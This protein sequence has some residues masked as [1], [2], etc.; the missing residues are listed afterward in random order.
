M[1]IDNIISYINLAG[2]LIAPVGFFFWVKFKI[3]QTDEQLTELKQQHKEDCNDI[4]KTFKEELLSVKHGKTALK[5][6]LQDKL[7]EYKEDQKEINDGL[8][9][10]IIQ[11]RNDISASK[12]EILTAISNIK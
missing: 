12:S 8:R 10:D 7:K 6:D 5:R 4:R 2:M 9:K 3:G 11:L 1:E